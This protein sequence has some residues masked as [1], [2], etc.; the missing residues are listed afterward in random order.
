MAKPITYP[1]EGGSYVRKSNGSFDRV[2]AT[3]P[4]PPPDAGKPDEQPAAPPPAPTSEK[5]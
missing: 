2:E 4:A 5:E 1:T 3:K